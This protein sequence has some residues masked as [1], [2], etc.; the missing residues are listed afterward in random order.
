MADATDWPEA[1]RLTLDGGLW[2]PHDADY[3]VELARAGNVQAAHALA[4]FAAGWLIGGVPLPQSVADWLADGLR[5]AVAKPDQ[6][7]AALGLTPGK[8]APSARKTTLRGGLEH[9][10]G[11]DLV[12]MR[13]REGAPLRSRNGTRDDEL[14]PAFVE[15]FEIARTLGIKT[16]PRALRDARYPR[17]K[18]GSSK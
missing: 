17:K 16:D 13:N 8:G 15:A 9:S 1:P 5:A 6:A 7:G 12:E 3:I 4:S 11:R 2:L 14:G 18:R 10:I